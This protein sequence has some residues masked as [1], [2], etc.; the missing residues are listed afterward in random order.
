MELQ[1]F[2]H[3]EL[4]QVRTVVK[5]E[6]P[7]FVAKDVASILDIKDAWS[8]TRY[9]DEDEKLNLSLGGTGQAR[10]TTVISESGLYS[11]IIRSRKPEAKKFKK[12]VTSEV[13]PTIRKTGGYVSDSD[14]MVETYYY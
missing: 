2:T 14:K 11:A 13:L 7:W 12:W 1:N 10:E 8:L 4:G 3:N 6:E 9:L 5:N